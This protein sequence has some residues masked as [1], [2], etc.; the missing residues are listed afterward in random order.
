MKYSTAVLLLVGAMTS[1]EAL[2]LQQM[3][4]S[5]L[6]ID[7]NESAQKHNPQDLKLA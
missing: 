4:A 3:N 6:D 5:E 7:T 2:K 1:T